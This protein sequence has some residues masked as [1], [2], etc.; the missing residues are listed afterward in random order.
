MK[1][2][3]I[4][5][6]TLAV[7]GTLAAQQ[8]TAPR[9]ERRMGGPAQMDSNKDGKISK[10]EWKGP[11]DRF[12]QLDSNGDGYL[13]RDEMAAGGRGGPNGARGQRGASRDMDTNNDGVI[14]RDEWKGPA[15]AFDRLDVNHDGSIS[16]DEL[17]G[18]RG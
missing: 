1:L 9:G 4:G 6:L 15:Q 17:Q 7:A 2:I 16:R 11:A 13:T 10:D 8:G 3:S 14:S 12:T 18:I 5:V